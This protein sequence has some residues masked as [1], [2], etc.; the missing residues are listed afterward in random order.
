M[1]ELDNLFENLF[2]VGSELLANLW[3]GLGYPY[4]EAVISLW[5]STTMT[6]R[7]GTSMDS[8]AFPPP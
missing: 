1:A 5:W 7:W 2:G 8:E 4:W 3:E 6:S